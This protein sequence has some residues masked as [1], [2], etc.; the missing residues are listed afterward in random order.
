LKSGDNRDFF[1]VQALKD[2]AGPYLDDFGLCVVRGGDDPRLA[3]GEAGRLLPLKGEGHS[4]EGDAD[5]L[6]DRNKHILFTLRRMW[7]D[8]AGEPKELVG[9]I[10]H[11]AYDYDEPGI[12]QMALGNPAG[13]GGKM[14]GRRHGGAPKFHHEKR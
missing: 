3:P 6:A 1:F 8:L 13:N 4:E 5:P 11:G 2:P 9:R 12:V 7:M 14:G 10:P